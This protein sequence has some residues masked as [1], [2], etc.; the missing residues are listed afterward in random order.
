MLTMK[1]N[2]IALALSAAFAMATA[3]SA[4]GASVT[5]D[6]IN[7]SSASDSSTNGLYTTGGFTTQGNRIG[8]FTAAKYN[9]GQVLVGATFAA[10]LANEDVSFTRTGSG[11]TSP[12]A[13][14]YGSTN[15]SVA[16]IV[17]NASSASINSGTIGSGGGTTGTISSYTVTGTATTPAQLTNLYGSGSVSGTVTEALYVSKTDG[18]SG[19]TV[20]VDNS[21]NRTASVEYT[22]QTV[23]HANGSFAASPDT[24]SLNLNFGTIVAGTTPA[25]L[26]FNLYNA[27]GSWGLHVVSANYSGSGLFSLG[28]VGTGITNL[29]AGSF[30][31]G[32][33]NMASTL[34]AGNY[35]GLWTFVVADSSTSSMAAGRN[36]GGTDTLTLAVNA[37]VAAVPEPGEWAMML[38]GFGLIGLMANRKRRRSI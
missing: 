34:A 6:S 27:I 11:S 29:A 37:Q 15:L 31:G 23:N 28:G 32:V 19:Y 14:A 33:V 18:S 30:V 25:S 35:S 9:G 8:D 21:S 16:G 17:A 22:Y 24:N 5:T 13:S 3:G 36:F 10:T 4:L 1:T 26:A 7:P 12:T 38:A 2:K 20:Q